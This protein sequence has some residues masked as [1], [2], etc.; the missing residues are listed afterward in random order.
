MATFK[1]QV[2]LALMA[3]TGAIVAT[4]APALIE[5]EKS[6]SESKPT[7]TATSI[8]CD[9]MSLTKV[10]IDNLTVQI[11]SDEPQQVRKGDRLFL[12]SG[13]TLRISS[14]NYCIPS[15]ARVNRVEVKGYFFENGVTG[16][17]NPLFTRIPFP[18]NAACHHIGSFQ[19]TWTLQS[20]GQHGVSIPIIKYVDSNRIVDPSFY[21]DL[22]VER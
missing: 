18:I 22:D 8:T 10:C 12:K 16:Y 13:D 3:A 19:K 4:V 7:I 20:S 14:L 6:S 1:E 15:Q 11:N 9:K 17:K 21:F 5:N 2:V